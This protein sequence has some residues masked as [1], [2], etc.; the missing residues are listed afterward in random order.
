M[1]PAIFIIFCFGVFEISCNLY[2]FISTDEITNNYYSYFNEYT[3]VLL[4]GKV[5]N[6]VNILYP[7]ISYYSILR[8]EE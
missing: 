6:L 4:N 3:K 8:K 7:A 1:K 5:Q 2:L